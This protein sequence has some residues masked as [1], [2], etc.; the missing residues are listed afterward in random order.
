M[1]KEV[2]EMTKK[3]KVKLDP[4]E[5]FASHRLPTKRKTNTHPVLVRLNNLRKKG[6]LIRKSKEMKLD[7]IYVNHYLNTYTR[8]LL[9]RARELRDKSYIQF[10]RFGNGFVKVRK[11]SVT[12]V[13]RIRSSVDLEEIRDQG[14]QEAT[15]GNREEEE[16]EDDSKEEETAKSTSKNVLHKGRGG[17]RNQNHILSQSL[18]R[19]HF[20]RSQK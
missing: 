3:W 18:I 19:E 1:M 15:R 2:I 9:E 17:K 20:T 14:E 6:E 12:R 10:S 13:I 8:Q 4:L 5:I 11:E 7:G 16:N